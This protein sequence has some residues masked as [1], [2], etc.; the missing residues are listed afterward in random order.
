MLENI[1]WLELQLPWYKMVDTDASQEQAF[2]IPSKEWCNEIKKA[3]LKELRMLYSATF[4]CEQRE[5]TVDGKTVNEYWGV[6]SGFRHRHREWFTNIIDGRG[7]DSVVQDGKLIEDNLLG[8]K[9]RYILE[10]I[11]QKM[12]RRGIAYWNENYEQHDSGEQRRSDGGT[13]SM[14]FP[15]LKTLDGL[16]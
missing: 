11:C 7:S 8:V 15:S 12:G 2:T 1:R 3:N 9:R 6:K 5:V 13:R 4:L 10:Q 14:Y 16:K